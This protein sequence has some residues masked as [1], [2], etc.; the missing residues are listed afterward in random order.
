MPATTATT[1]ATLRRRRHIVLTT[2]RKSG[3]AVSTPV[4]FAERDGKLYIYTG[5]NTG[6]VKR[7]RNDSHV[8]VAPSTM[9]GKVRGPAID[10]R[11]RILTPEEGAMADHAL[12]RKYWILRPLND[13]LN[14]ALRFA[15]GRRQ[16]PNIVYLEVEPAPSYT[17][18]QRGARLTL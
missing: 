10:G 6:K 12:T 8:T 13:A 4:W 16:P 1:F 7:I 18:W 3:E 14:A 17:D 9:M 15:R 2:F 5:A 11:A